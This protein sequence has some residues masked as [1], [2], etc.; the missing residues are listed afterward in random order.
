MLRQ[1]Q[2]QMGQNIQLGSFIVKVMDLMFHSQHADWQS[3]STLSALELA[4]V[5]R[6]KTSREALVPLRT[7]VHQP[8]EE[9]IVTTGARESESMESRLQKVQCFWAQRFAPPNWYSRFQTM[10]SNYVD[11]LHASGVCQ[12]SQRTLSPDMIE[13]FFT[14]FECTTTWFDSRWIRDEL[15]QL[16]APTYDLDLFLF[17]LVRLSLVKFDSQAGGTNDIAQILATFDYLERQDPFHCF[18]PPDTGV[19]K[20]A[21]DPEHYTS[22]VTPTII[23]KFISGVP[24]QDID[25]LHPAIPH[26]VSIG[27]WMT[28]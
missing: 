14:T 13:G 2:T 22:N 19:I 25:V 1:V 3:L 27:R 10:F 23:Q 24:S 6:L 20:P 18:P 9:I 26:E 12:V 28:F 15:S 8:E 16:N 21:L 17:L 7:N 11:L 4:V 5:E